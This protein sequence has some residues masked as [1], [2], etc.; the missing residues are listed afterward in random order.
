MAKPKRIIVSVTND[1]ST[2]QRVDKV[3]R[4]LLSQGYS[5]ILVGRLRKNSKPVIN[6]PYKTKRLRLLFDKGPLFYAAFNFRLFFYLVIRRTDLLLANDLDTLLGN[7]VATKFK[8]STNLVYDSHEYFTEVPELKGRKAKKIWEGIEAWILPNIETCYTVNE[9]ISN[10]YFS[11]YGKKMSVVRNISPLWRQTNLLS[12]EE[13]GLPID[14]KIIIIQGAGINVDR[15]AEEAVEAMKFVQNAVLIIVGDGDVVPQLKTVVQ[16]QNMEDKVL[17][18]PKQ[19][20]LRMMNYT[21]HSDIGLTLDKATNINYQFSLPNKVFDYIHT[22]TP[23]IATNLV[24][25]ARIVNDYKVGHILTTF[26]ALSL[27]K[28]IN[29]LLTQ[30]D[31]LI[32]YKAN[33]EIAQQVLNWENETKVL[34]NIYPKSDVSK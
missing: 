26:D 16:L 2:D 9:S 11:K 23:I 25:V 33:C 7:Y 17:F 10:L 3:C 13:L 18:F 14:K 4:F 34:E 22:G 5:V 20:Y 30:E 8:S 29:D 1:L 6:R 12:K 31:R 24:E 28:A 27:S 32:E 15:G 19:E 21:F